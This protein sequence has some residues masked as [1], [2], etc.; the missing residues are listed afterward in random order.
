MEQWAI[1]GGGGGSMC[2]SVKEYGLGIIEENKATQERLTT[3]NHTI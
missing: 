3:T 2:A 1:G